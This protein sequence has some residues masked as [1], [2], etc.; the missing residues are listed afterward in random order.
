[1]PLFT[2]TSRNREFAF[3]VHSLIGPCSDSSE[4]RCTSAQHALRLALITRD[5]PLNRQ[6]SVYFSL[7]AGNFVE[8]SSRVTAS[9]ASL[10]RFCVG[11]PWWRSQSAPHVAADTG[12]A[13]LIRW[14]SRGGFIAFQRSLRRCTFSQKSGVLPKTRARMSAVAA[15]TLRRLLQNSLT[16]LRCTAIAWASAPCVS[17]ICFMNSSIKI[18]PTLAGLRFVLNTVHHTNSFGKLSNFRRE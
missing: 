18:S 9:S 10:E 14:R 16:C 15:V 13:R 17:P 7:L 2:G 1:M 12:R 5:L 11:R 6:N 8:K 4:A 3:L